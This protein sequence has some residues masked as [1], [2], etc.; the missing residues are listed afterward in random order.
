M[1]NSS[2]EVAKFEGAAIKTVSGIR[3]QIK[4]AIRTPDGAFRA[5]FVDKLLM[6]DIVFLRTWYP[7][8]CQIVCENETS[9]NPSMGERPPNSDKKRQFVQTNCAKGTEVQQ[10]ENPKEYS[11]EFAIHE[12]TQVGESAPEKELRSETRGGDDRQAEK[13]CHT[14][15]R[16]CNHQEGQRKEEKGETR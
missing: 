6:S 12:Q 3:G 15:A 9:A 2:L 16:A 10:T 11:S 8:S 4:K 5:T 7:S 1:F 13:D 14:L